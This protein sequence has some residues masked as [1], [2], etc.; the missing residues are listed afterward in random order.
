MINAIRD[1]TGA[2]GK[3]YT[4][5]DMTDH[6]IW[7]TVLDADSKDYVLSTA[8]HKAEKDSLKTLGITTFHAYT[9]I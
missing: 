9:L 4:L 5:A 2:P 8:S 7:D 1:L 3:N 6:E